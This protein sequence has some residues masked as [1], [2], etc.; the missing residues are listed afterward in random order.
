MVT[1]PPV[2]IL[3][4]LLLIVLYGF[5]L[6][7]FQI[8]GLIDIPSVLLVFALS[9]LI[10]F[11]ITNHIL[12]RFLLFTD[13]PD[14]D[15]HYHNAKAQSWALVPI[16]P[17]IICFV[18]L[19]RYMDNPTL[20]GSIIAIA[21]IG[22]LYCIM[23]YVLNL[24]HECRSLLRSHRETRWMHGHFRFLMILG[25]SVLFVTGSNTVGMLYIFSSPQEAFHTLTTFIP[26]FFFSSIPF[27]SSTQSIIT[28]L[29]WIAL[30]ALIAKWVFTPTHLTAK[31][32]SQVFLRNF[33]FTL[34]ISAYIISI[35]SFVHLLQ[36]LDSPE[37]L[38]R[39]AVFSIYFPIL[40]LVLA[41][42]LEWIVRRNDT[43]ETSILK[44]IQF[45]SAKSFS[46]S[47]FM[48]C[49]AGLIMGLSV[50]P[51][52]GES[53][54]ISFVAFSCLIWINRRR[55]HFENIIAQRT[56]ELEAEKAL[57]EAE[58][59]RKTQ[60]LEEARQLQLSMLPQASLD[61]P[62]IAI[63]FDMKLATE[64]GGDYFDFTLSTDRT[65]MVALGDA[66][67][68]G[69]RAGILVTAT[70]SLFQAL[71]HETDI[72][73]MFASISQTLKL[74]NL[75]RM[76]MALTL[77]KIADRKLTISAAGMPP[78]LIYRAETKKVEEILLEGLHP[79][80]TLLIM[81]DGLPERMNPKGD[82][83]DYDRVQQHFAN[84]ADHTPQDI[85]AQ[86]WE[87]GE[88]WSQ[89]LPQDD[90]ITLVA[91]KIK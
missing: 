6:P 14:A 7:N 41:S 86:M 32:E 59:A 55:I 44:P 68:H 47:M 75:Q 3:T 66:T 15:Y 83:F 58:N 82:L 27:L 69:L 60:E 16:F 13:A 52:V 57:V 79:G 4:V 11:A 65:L 24:G 29:L 9:F 48:V 76:N 43:L 45:R 12:P 31:I 35:V 25:F 56:A 2:Y 80:D 33:I 10:K 77:I 50:F 54:A 19:I 89:G 71:S 67:G 53:I 36:N 70:K 21:I 40:S 91:F 5:N 74:M 1:N 39:G 78:L 17:A 34:T 42:P 20:I 18:M 61:H 23:G 37:Q 84:I 62:D 88:T 8:N 49:V 28:L 26:D 85:C 38:W 46:V 22:P 87:A 72:L 30:S 73:Q 63:A 90:D 81:S 64:V 51:E